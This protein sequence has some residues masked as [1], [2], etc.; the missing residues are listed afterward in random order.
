[1]G[2]SCRLSARPASR[3]GNGV[4]SATSAPTRNC[5]GVG[6]TVT[7]PERSTQAAM[8]RACPR[9]RGATSLGCRTIRC[10]LKPELLLRLFQGA[11][12]D[13]HLGQNFRG[14]RELQ[15]ISVIRIKF[16][17]VRPFDA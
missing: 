13:R 7:I 6:L 15:E 17:L 10:S 11:N 1:M 4:V 16:A 12:L 2:S 14:L 9:C 3:A 8:R 5:Q